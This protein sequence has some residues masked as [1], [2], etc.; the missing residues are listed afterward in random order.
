MDVEAITVGQIVTTISVVGAIA[1]A[2]KSVSDWLKKKTEPIDK[3]NDEI[4]IIKRNQNNDNIRL[5]DLEKCSKLTLKATRLLLEE[6]INNDD[7]DGKL[8]NVA[9][10]IDEYLYE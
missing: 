8:A 9:N 4:E 1:M 3:V 7:K 6:R 2:I 5:K 10:D